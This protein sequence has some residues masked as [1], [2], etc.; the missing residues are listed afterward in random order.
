MDLAGKAAIVTG[1]GTGVG[2]ATSL[3]LARRGCS[4]LLNYSR[5]KD[6]AE[7][8]AG[9]VEAQGVR[10]IPLRADVADD[11]ACRGM[12]ELAAREFG[13]LDVLVN[14]AGTTVFVPHAELDRLSA[15]DFQRVYAVN[16]IGPFQCARAARGPML[17][18]GGGGEVV[19]ISSVAGGGRGRQLDSVLPVQGGAQQPH[20]HAGSRAG[21]GDPRQ[22]R[23]PGT[24]R[25]SLDARLDERRAD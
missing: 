6:E 8:T 18:S 24:D 20:H 10:A 25:H 23:L 16:A 4:V 1:G 9:E 17:E 13:R 19:N 5:S 21:A 2:R 3:E 12:V 7:A 11:D 22:R 14:N 15:E